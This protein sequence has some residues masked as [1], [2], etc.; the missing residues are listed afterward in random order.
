MQDYINSNHLSDIYNVALNNRIALSVLGLGLNILDS[1]FTVNRKCSLLKEIIKS[2][3]Y[4]N[5]CKTLIF[6]YFPLHW[7]LFYFCA[8]HRLSFSLYC[9]LSIIK[10]IIS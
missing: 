8:K 4:Q 3:R 2:Q 7:K 9:L 1:D 10:K 6:K 5:A